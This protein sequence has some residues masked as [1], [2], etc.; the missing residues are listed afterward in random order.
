M[1]VGYNT[2]FIDSHFKVKG[3]EMSGIRRFALAL[4]LCVPLAI[5]SQAESGEDP[6]D[7]EERGVTIVLTT[8]D[9]NDTKL[10]LHWKIKN[11]SDH[12]VWIC[13]R[14]FERYM[15]KDNQTLVIRSR[16]DLPIGGVILEKGLR[17][18]YIHLS[19]GQVRIGS[20]SLD[21]PIS[22]KVFLEA[23]IGNAIHAKR[24]ALEIGFY[25]EDL[26]ALILQIAESAEKLGCT[27]SI[28]GGLEIHGRY[29][30][31]LWIAGA[32]NDNLF[33]YFKESVE[34]GGE[35]IVMPHMGQARVG[36]QVLRL[37]VDGVS[38]PY[39]ANWPPLV[40][41]R[42]EVITNEAI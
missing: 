6:E 15:A 35:E 22:P 25:D 12:D 2:Y 5:P 7:E 10:D 29:F 23:E 21:L 28:V 17:A 36:E 13:L 30:A 14:D 39:E 1:S 41:K 18:R 16:F 9:M 27:G 38:I 40:G 33:P 34:N 42:G 24:I 3:L 8:L 26:R 32:Y 20:L 37:T 19:P 31:G 11:A 4:I